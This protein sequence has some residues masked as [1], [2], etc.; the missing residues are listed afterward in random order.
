MSRIQY[1]CSRL[2]V[3]IIS[4]VLPGLIVIGGIIIQTYGTAS[5]SPIDSFC[6]NARHYHAPPQLC[7]DVTLYSSQ[8][9]LQTVRIIVAA[10]IKF[11]PTF[12][13]IPLVPGVRIA[14]PTTRLVFRPRS[15]TPQVLAS[16][17]S[18]KVGHRKYPRCGVPTG[19]YVVLPLQSHSKAVVNA[20]TLRVR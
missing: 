7:N 15:L 17:H 18:F 12:Q 2:L 5:R 6:S 9:G 4:V 1:S 19:P 8:H 14:E 20:P 16:S 11:S 3:S 13:L 10:W